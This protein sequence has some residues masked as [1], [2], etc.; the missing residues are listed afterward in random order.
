GGRVL[1]GRGGGGWSG[2]GVGV[3][4]Q[5]ETCAAVGAATQ[6]PPEQ[7]CP[8]L[9]SE[10]L[11]QAG[12][13][14][15]PSSQTWPGLQSLELRQTATL[16]ATAGGAPAAKWKM[17]NC[18]QRSGGGERNCVFLGVLLLSCFY[19]ICPP[20]LPKTLRQWRQLSGEVWGFCNLK[21]GE[22][23]RA[24]SP[25]TI[26]LLQDC[27]RRFRGNHPALLRLSAIISPYFIRS[28]FTAAFP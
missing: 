7:I 1:G 16:G 15:V 10:S 28:G 11:P 24:E 14:Q 12:A 23:C 18:G 13:M 4:S 22:Y 25:S 27:N 21:R 3:T 17:A 19:E 9:Q 26:E 6:A 8:A 5:L 20:K 2:G